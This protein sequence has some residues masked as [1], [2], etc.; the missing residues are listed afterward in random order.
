MIQDVAPHRFDPSYQGGAVP[1]PHD[2]LFVFSDGKLLLT[3][4]EPGDVPD[5]PCVD[6]LPANLE[7]TY[8][9]GLD[10]EACWGAL[11]P[12]PETASELAQACTVPGARFMTLHEIRAA[13]G[14]SPAL[15]LALHTAYHLGLWKSRNRFCGICAHPMTHDSAE[16]ALRCPSCGNLVYPRINPAVIVGV[17]DPGHKRIVLTRYARGRG[18]TYDALVA[19]FVEVGETLEQCVA[20]EVYEELGLRVKNIRYVASQPWGMAADVLAGFWCDVDGDATLRLDEHELSRAVWAE[21]HEVVGQPD[22]L[23]L[24]NHMMCLFRDGKV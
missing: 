18:V 7:L 22:D 20:R 6:D 16:R 17:L 5:V 8:A 15:T 23:S 3:H 9:F 21:P 13:G 12:E 11:A 1:Q 2:R 24:T 4:A 10:G 14:C 19:G